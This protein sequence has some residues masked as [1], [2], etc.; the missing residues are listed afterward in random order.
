MPIKEIRQFNDWLEQV[1]ASLQQRYKMFLERKRIVEEQMTELQEIL[2]TVNYKCRFY[3]T[4]I[5]TGTEII[6]HSD[7]EQD[8]INSC[9]EKG[10]SKN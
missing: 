10:K 8:F 4:A 2:D 3:E 9:L 6:H 1:D 7:E 5:A